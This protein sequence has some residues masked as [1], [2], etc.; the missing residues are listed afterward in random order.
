MKNSNSDKPLEKLNQYEKELELAKNSGDT[1]KILEC[2]LLLGKLCSEINA[3][4][5]ALKYVE[6][7]FSLGIKN[8]SNEYKF[9]QI[10]GDLRLEQGALKE[11]YNAYEVSNKKALKTG[12]KE[13]QAE[14]YF[15]LAN[16]SKLLEKAPKNTITFLEKSL[17]IYNLLNR[18][19]ERANI[20]YQLGVMTIWG[21]SFDMADKRFFS[22]APSSFLVSAVS[23]ASQKSKAKK[24]MGAQLLRSQSYFVDALNVLEENNLVESQNT[25]YKNISEHLKRVEE[26]KIKK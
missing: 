18:H 11:A 22:S 2:L 10:L 19:I 25:L 9:Y 13:C 26:I 24:V 15:K 17:E 8:F 20:M 12:D 5:L 4:E 23:I 6:D 3:N 7:A 21:E 16:V 14:N 1:S